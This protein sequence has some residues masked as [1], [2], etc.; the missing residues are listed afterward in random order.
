MSQAVENTITSVKLIKIQHTYNNTE[1]PIY[2][3]NI[4]VEGI[5]EPLTV[6]TTAIIDDSIIGNKLQ[7][8]LSKN[9]EVSNFNL[10]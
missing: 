9:N 1:K 3:Y 2:Y 8:N 4:K 10:I 7:Y 5:N 6:E